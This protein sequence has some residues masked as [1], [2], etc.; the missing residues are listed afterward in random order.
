M[1]GHSVPC[2]EPIFEELSDDSSIFREGDNRSTYITRREYSELIA[3]FSGA[4]ARIRNRY[5]CSK[6]VV[7]IFLETVQDIECSS[8]SSD[9]S[10]VYFHYFLTLEI[11]WIRLYCFYLLIQPFMDGSTLI[12]LLVIVAV[13]VPMFIKK[14]SQ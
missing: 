8:T 4:S 2:L 5:D 11:D 10:D 6:I 7:F 3:D 14:I 13:V 12:I 1:P 9:S